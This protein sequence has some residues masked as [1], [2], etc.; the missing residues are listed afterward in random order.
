MLTGYRNGVKRRK[1]ATGEGAAELFAPKTRNGSEPFQ[2]AIL[3]AFQRR[4]P[5]ASQNAQAGLAVWIP[6]PNPLCRSP[7]SD[8]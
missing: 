2:T 6:K 5:G 1:I 7:N 3:G 4:V 8:P